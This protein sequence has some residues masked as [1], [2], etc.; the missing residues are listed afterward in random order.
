MST[1]GAAAFVASRFFPP[2]GPVGND[3][4]KREVVG[5]RK[6]DTLDEFLSKRV[7][8]AFQADCLPGMSIF[9]AGDFISWE[10]LASGNE[11]QLE[12]VE[13]INGM[14]IS[15]PGNFIEKGRVLLVPAGI[16]RYSDRETIASN[17]YN[18]LETKVVAD[19][20]VEE[21]RQFLPRELERFNGMLSDWV[22]PYLDKFAPEK[23]TMGMVLITRVPDSLSASY[24][25]ETEHVGVAR[26]DYFAAGGNAF[27]HYRDKDGKMVLT[28]TVDGK[29]YGRRIYLLKEPPLNLR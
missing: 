5:D 20:L 25:K 23:A 24:A 29:I 10:S 8:R 13:Q 19:P 22:M 4:K 14:K 2:I 27:S 6:T 16:G 3:D 21:E 11:N 26:L 28:N 15:K 9:I 1:V 18:R 17:L 12:K 7:P